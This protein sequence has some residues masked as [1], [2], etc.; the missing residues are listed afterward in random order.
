MSRRRKLAIFALAALFGISTVSV[1][2]QSNAPRGTVKVKPRF[3]NPFNPAPRSSL[4]ISP[5]GVISF[6]Q[7]STVSLAPAAVATT[8][9][10]SS[11]AE[12]ASVDSPGVSAGTGRPPFRPTPRSGF[13][14]PPRGQLGP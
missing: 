14:P 10:A 4:S 2:A 6:A 11:T 9:A 5:F 1:Q 8:V 7:A 3:F 13:R 12:S